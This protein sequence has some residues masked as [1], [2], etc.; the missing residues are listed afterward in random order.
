MATDLV[1]LACLQ[2]MVIGALVADFSA[3]KS[4]RK[5]REALKA[6]LVATQRGLAELHNK[7]AEAMR[8]LQDKVNAHA[9]ALA[10]GVKLK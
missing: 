9:M 6:E 3:R 7:N 1:I 2:G 4:D 8:G 10:S 5:D